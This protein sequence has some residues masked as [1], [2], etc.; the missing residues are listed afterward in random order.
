M[1]RRVTNSQPL[2]S[3]QRCQRKQ[4][5]CHVETDNTN[6]LELQASDANSGFLAHALAVEQTSSERGWPYNSFAV[7]RHST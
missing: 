5:Y 2:T 1:Q 4:G 3:W 6:P 7:V